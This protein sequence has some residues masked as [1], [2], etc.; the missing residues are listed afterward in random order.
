M[1]RASQFLALKSVAG[2]LL[3]GVVLSTSLL[4]A[5]APAKTPPALSSSAGTPS[6]D[7]VIRRSATALSAIS[8]SPQSSGVEG[9]ND[10]A[11]TSILDAGNPLQQGSGSGLSD[12]SQIDVAT[13]VID[14]IIW[15]IQ[16]GPA[17]SLPVDPVVPE[18]QDPSLT[19]DA[20][21]A[22]FALL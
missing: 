2:K 20:L 1:N 13:S 4:V 21:E 22:A 14:T 5:C 18:G 16:T 11:V 6:S 8:T 19:E 15:Q 17:P 7:I 10:P 9:D 12:D 3:I